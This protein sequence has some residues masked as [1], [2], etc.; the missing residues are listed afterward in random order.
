MTSEQNRQ[1]IID[2]AHRLFGERGYAGTSIGDVAEQAGLLK[3]NLSYYFKTKAEL[4]EWVTVARQAELLGRLAAG[5]APDASA[6]DSLE[7]FLQVTEASAA[8]L[9]RVG[10]P[11]G[12]LCSE[13]GKN[14]P[15]LQPY[16][17]RVLEALH[18]W[19][20]TQFERLVPADLAGAYAEQLLAQL[21]GA[22]VL[23]HAYRDP[24]VVHRQVQQARRW[25]LAIP[26][27]PERRARD[28]A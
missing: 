14:D 28:P 6:M 1:R 12:T 17:S 21:Q 24:G 4:L 22:A 15:A 20:A 5:L 26:T 13:L 18:G 16:A 25:L 10:C 8:E 2:A 9:A 27:A 3:G 19:L 7:K 23:A 11:V